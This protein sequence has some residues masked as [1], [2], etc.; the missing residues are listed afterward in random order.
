VKGTIFELFVS[1]INKSRQS[2]KPDNV[3]RYVALMAVAKEIKPN[4]IWSMTPCIFVDIN[5]LPIAWD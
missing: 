2:Q 3:L 4:P 1:I 5:I